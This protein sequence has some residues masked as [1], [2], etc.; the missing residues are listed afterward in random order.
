MSEKKNWLDGRLPFL[1]GYTPSD[2]NKEIVKSVSG[3]KLTHYEIATDEKLIRDTQVS[4]ANYYMGGGLI[5][6]AIIGYILTGGELI[7][8]PLLAVGIGLLFF[9][10][11][12]FVPKK[13]IILNRKDGLI[14]Y[15]DWFFKKPHTILFN[16]TKVFWTSMGGASGAL[17][18]RLVT[19]APNS[20]R[21]I[22]L[23]MH[24]GL[25]DHSWSLIVWYMDKNRPLPPGDAFDPYRQKD[26]ERRKA[27]GFPPPLY[28]S[29]FP[30]PEAT[31]EQQEERN[32][33]WRD[34]DYY[35]D[36]DSAWY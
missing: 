24:P 19:S 10:Y 29:R 25:F 15:P 22:D 35:G 33:H 34:E 23:R 3:E 18:Q 12:Y 1:I 5:V 31:L 32:R 30:I 26:F 9:L 13:E 28:P 17:S 4:P 14:T 27:E 2:L 8:G 7:S 21:A 16:E 6:L 11:A 20:S 36:S